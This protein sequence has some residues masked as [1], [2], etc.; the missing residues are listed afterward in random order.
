MD[1]HGEPSPD[2]EDTPLTTTSFHQCHPYISSLA[3]R[4]QLGMCL[5]CTA[6]GAGSCLL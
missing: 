2:L 6:L 4:S 1:G 3:R 5:V